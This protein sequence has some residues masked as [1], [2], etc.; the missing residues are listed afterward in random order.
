MSRSLSQQNVGNTSPVVQRASRINR[1]RRVLEQAVCE[2]LEQRRLLSFT[3]QYSFWDGFPEGGVHDEPGGDSIQPD[4]NWYTSFPDGSSSLEPQDHDVVIGGPYAQA[5]FFDQSGTATGEVSADDVRGRNSSDDVISS[6]WDPISSYEYHIVTGS[7]LGFHEGTTFSASA[8]MN[9]TDSPDRSW[10]FRAPVYDVLDFNLTADTCLITAN[11]VR[12]SD[13]ATA[14]SFDDLGGLSQHLDLSRAISTAALSTSGSG[15]L[16]GG[17]NL[18][19]IPYLQNSFP[20]TNGYGTLS[21]SDILGLIWDDSTG[22][23]L[24]ETGDNEWTISSES[25]G[26]RFYHDDTAHEYIWEGS[27]GAK[28]IFADFTGL[29][30]PSGKF[31][32]S[33]SA[34]GQEEHVTWSS[35]L[36]TSIGT[37]YDDPYSSGTI[38][39]SLDFTYSGGKVSRATLSRDS[40][41]VRTVDYTY[42][43]SGQLEWVTIRD[44]DHTAPVV[45][46]KYYRWYDGTT[47]EGRAGDLKLVMGH[48]AILFATAALTGS[49]TLESK[50]DAFLRDYADQYLV[51][52][53]YTENGVEQARVIEQTILGDGAGCGCGVGNE[54]AGVYRYEYEDE[55]PTHGEV[56]RNAWRNKTIEYLPD[57][58]PGSWSDND[59]RIVYTNKWGQPILDIVKDTAA[60]TEHL[61]WYRYNS[62]GQE[63]LRAQSSAITGYDSDLADL[64]DFGESGSYLSEDAGLLHFTEYYTAEDNV[65]ESLIGYTKRTGVQRGEAGDQVPLYAYTYTDGAIADDGVWFV[66]TMT[67]Y[68]GDGTRELVTKYDYVFHVDGSTPTNQIKKRTIS[69]PQV[70]GAQNGADSTSGSFSTNYVSETYYDAFGNIIWER[71]ADGYINYYERDTATGAIT[72]QIIDADPTAITTNP[73]DIA[74]SRGSGL[75]SALALITLREVDDRGRT[76]KETDPNGNITYTV[77]DDTLED[78][79]LIETRTYQG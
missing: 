11:G 33:V 49:E 67:E 15:G 42:D 64:V 1:R 26:G 9:F 46:Q 22:W 28:T 60:N 27:D 43:T 25:A 5:D 2:T 68:G 23:I 41:P 35:G 59:Q 18:E 36:P 50:S 32:R 37:T 72:K 24:L 76:I 56:G 14:L 55:T 57:D 73:L 75:P 62:R 58:T 77:Y 34:A 31:L 12:P 66:E 51:Y 16:F 74:P 48:E 53:R 63:I 8:T 65:A 61:T 13:G 45:E 54:G 20:S 3:Y 6:P 47:S 4:G 71:D 78:G 52:E 79:D 38:A 69:R 29:A 70:D 44:G 39:E 7:F 30:G 19:S 21:R 40:V 10:Y 17:F